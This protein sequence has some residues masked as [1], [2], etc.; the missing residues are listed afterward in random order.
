[1]RVTMSFLLRTFILFLLAVTV[2]A[3]QQGTATISGT[4]TDP[5]DAAI[6]AAVV[7]IR[8]TGTGAESRAVTNDAGF[9]TAPGVPVG[10]Y[11]V[12]VQHQGFKSAVR[13]G[14]TVQVGQNAQVNVR[15]ELGQT[16]EAIQVTAEVPLVD[17]G[18]ATVGQVIENRRVTDLPING[19][20]A[21]ALTLLNPGV[22]SNAG[23]T[24]SGFGDRGV[25]ISSLSINGSPNGMNAQM[26]DGANNVLSYVGEVGIP[27][28]VDSVEASATISLTRVTRSPRCVCLS[29][30]T[31][32]A[33]R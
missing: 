14:I 21:L 6:G 19:R 16:T 33:D 17:T 24:Q 29:A 30:T 31:S 7:Q 8:N 32:T 11:E 1:M 23:P 4:V 26:L 10:D 28:A 15:L 5:Q 2:C 3:A 27:P 25:D 12:T 9:Y 22:V 18:T 13:K 20:N